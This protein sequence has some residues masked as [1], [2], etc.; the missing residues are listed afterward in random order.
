MVGLKREHKTYIPL[1][2]T[3]E[4]K[5]KTQDPSVESSYTMNSEQQ[6][7]SGSSSDADKYTEDEESSLESDKEKPSGVSVAGVKRD[8]ESDASTSSSRPSKT[9]KVDHCDGTSVGNW[10][11]I[12]GKTSRIKSLGTILTA[13]ERQRGCNWKIAS[14]V[15]TSKR[16]PRPTKD[17]QFKTDLSLE[18]RDDPS[19]YLEIHSWG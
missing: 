19:V 7:D 3:A 9:L 14:Y 17:Q 15:V 6:Q 2:V 5:R 10:T 12:I 4:S 13:V 11:P 18:A 8:L 1:D 16:H